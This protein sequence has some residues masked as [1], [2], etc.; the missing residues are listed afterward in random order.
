MEN[1][2]VEGAQRGSSV[3]GRAGAAS[4]HAPLAALWARQPEAHYVGVKAHGSG[5]WQL[6]CLHHLRLERSAS[7]WPECAPTGR[8]FLAAGIV[9]Y[10]HRIVRARTRGLALRVI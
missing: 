3:S 4:R 6:T 1:G 10:A 2:S 8:D 9:L 5:Q 7:A